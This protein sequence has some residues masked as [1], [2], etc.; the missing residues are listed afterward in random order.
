[1]V[2][3]AAALLLLTPVGFSTPMDALKPFE[4][5]QLHMGVRVQI[6]LFATDRE[7]AERACEAA[8]ARFAQL[9]QSMSDYRPS[10]EIRRL[11]AAEPGVQVRVT[12]DLYRVLEQARRV[13]ALSDGAFD[14]TCAP[15]VSLW[16]EAFSSKVLPA[17]D[18]LAEAKGRVGSR[19]FLL[20][21][22]NQSVELRRDG[23]VFDLGG[24][25]KGYACDEALRTLSAKG[26][27]RA[28]VEAG[29]DMAASDP[30][31]GKEGWRIAIRGAA[32]QVFL[33]NQALSTSGDSA[34][35][36]VID[37]VRYSHIIDPRTGFGLTG[38]RQ[39]SVVARRGITTDP[40]ATALSV[41]GPEGEPIAAVFGATRVIWAD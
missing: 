22:A 8:F 2:T 1:M 7:T 40:L 11:A 20:D 12:S 4:Y 27:T 19:H 15:L 6:S 5:S 35:F 9:E 23:I 26:V 3:M 18:A 37:D 14:I 28:L 29:G 25:A 31:P 36:V 10:S 13:S 24:I 34:Q 41:L 39:V 30:P 33:K 17:K 21:A 32:D 38:A 16:R